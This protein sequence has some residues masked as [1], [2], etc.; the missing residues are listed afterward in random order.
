[1]PTL[2]ELFN[3]QRIN[4]GPNA[5]KTIAE[6]N[7][8]RNSKEIPLTSTNSV[9]RNTATSLVNKIRLKSKTRLSETFGEQETTG[10]RI[11]SKLATPILYGYDTIRVTTKT[12][13]LVKD[14]QKDV[15]GGSLDTARQALNT[16]KNLTK[17]GL[18]NDTLKSNFRNVKGE[19]S[20][21]N[22]ASGISVSKLPLG[23]FFPR[24]LIPSRLIA[25]P[26]FNNNEPNSGEEYNTMKRVQQAINASKG[27][28]LGQ[29][30]AK[31]KDINPSNI[32]AKA[33][34]GAGINLAKQGVSSLVKKLREKGEAKL[35]KKAEDD[36]AFV[37]SS[38]QPYSTLVLNQRQL[39]INQLRDTG[40]LPTGEGIQ[41][42]NDLSTKFENTYTS[43]SLA[44]RRNFNLKYL[45]EKKVQDVASN[46]KL[47]SSKI[48]Y[49][50]SIEGRYRIT[51]KNDAINLSLPYIPKKGSNTTGLMDPDRSID[52]LDF[53][54]L[55]FQSV[56]NNAFVNFRATITG[57]T[58]TFSPS[59]DNHK[60]IGNPF[61]FYTYSAIERSVQFNFKVYALS[62]A[63]QV[64]NWKRL[65]FLSSLVY[66]QNYIGRAGAAVPP[67]IKLTLGD[68]YKNKE[69]FIE[70][71]IYTTDDN[72]PWETGL[73]ELNSS[74]KKYNKAR[75]YK[76]PKIVDVGITVKF[77]ETKNSVFTPLPLASG[78]NDT[79][80][81]PFALKN[82]RTIDLGDKLFHGSKF[83]QYVNRGEENDVSSNKGKTLN[84]TAVGKRFVPKTSNKALPLVGTSKNNETIGERLERIKKDK[85]TS[86]QAIFYTG[87]NGRKRRIFKDG[88]GGYLFEDGT[89]VPTN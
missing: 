3:T 81:D 73:E 71:L 44:A 27:S 16:A 31:I 18:S 78:S 38:L 24:T 12:T 40:I 11:Y 80:I 65:A 60:F 15:N 74:P 35:A 58:E 72:Y 1:M 47:H 37:Y 4:S 52:D 56:A 13:N 28:V 10:L 46:E 86:P 21:T 2:L 59:W 51:N 22:L 54:T 64:N 6:A 30:I 76:L 45:A 77:I 53:I 88:F 62:D 26:L 63:E 20:I 9:L 85:K 5:G 19:A 43:S 8:I 89:S 57:L 17:N 61:N 75:Y 70:S 33:L 67:F 79:R 84:D 55:K 48:Y 49:D 42:R 83:D 34:A 69:C 68:M 14:M 66:P 23:K 82:D 41:D 50:N 32:N 87:E 25:D 39:G 29:Q 7:D 36:G